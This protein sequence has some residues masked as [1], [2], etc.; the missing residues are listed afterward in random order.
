MFF[1]SK[2]TQCKSIVVGKNKRCSKSALKWT[3][4]CYL[5]Q[6]KTSTI[7]SLLLGII[8]GLIVNTVH[9]YFI[10]SK[11]ED[12]KK[13]MFDRIKLEAAKSIVHMDSFFNL[14]FINPEDDL[15]N[16][17]H[18]LNLS[19]SSFFDNYPEFI[20]LRDKILRT[21]FYKPSNAFKGDRPIA[22]L[23]AL[24]ID[25]KRTTLLTR[26]FL[27]RYGS[28][29]HEIVTQVL[30]INRRVG[31]LTD[32]FSYVQSRILEGE[33]VYKNGFDKQHADFLTDLYFNQI[34]CQQV[35][36]Y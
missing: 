30:K 1:L 19:D 21:D 32:V 22:L 33:Y 14:Y 2:K 15:S 16:Q 12:G 5:H 23:S 17:I 3:P 8:I 34:K 11:V 27:D 29:E 26:V 35:S 28:V 7:I 24:I 31:I 18:N 36:G 20:E 10:P 6:P 9:D 13:E 25:L 4:Y